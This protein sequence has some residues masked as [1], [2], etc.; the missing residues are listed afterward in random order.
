MPVGKISASGI[1]AY[2]NGTEIKG[3]KKIVLEGDETA[4]EI[5]PP[6]PPL[7]APSETSL[8]RRARH[9]A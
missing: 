3:V 4:I 6:G 9:L 5:L 8:T 1:R 2:V 7:P